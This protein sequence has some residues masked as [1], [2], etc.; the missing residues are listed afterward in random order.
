MTV[1][2]LLPVIAL[3]RFNYI[4]GNEIQRIRTMTTCPIITHV[5]TSLYLAKRSQKKKKSV[6]VHREKMPARSRKV[7]LLFGCSKKKERYK[8]HCKSVSF[9][10]FSAL[11]GGHLINNKQTLDFCKY[12]RPQRN[13][14]LL[15][16][17]IVKCR[18]IA[19][20]VLCKE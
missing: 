16:L 2:R 17:Q 1:K 11:S 5:S 8:A 10:K 7:L 14:Q 13:I 4:L 15:E 3:F 9:E 18:K 6:S 19:F 20:V 12:W